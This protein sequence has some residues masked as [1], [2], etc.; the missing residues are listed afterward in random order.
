M[1]PPSLPKYVAA[2]SLVAPRF[3][4]LSVIQ[5]QDSSDPHTFLGIQFE[6]QV[7]T[8]ADLTSALHCA[9]DDESP[10]GVPKV[11]DAGVPL[12]TA[13]PFAVYGSYR[14]NPVGR[15]LQEAFDRALAHLENGKSRAIERAVQLGEAGNEPSLASEAVDITP[16]GGAVSLV[17]AIAEAE[18]YLRENYAG[19]GVIHLT[20]R[21][22]TLAAANTLIYPDGDVLRTTL[23]TLVVAG[24]GY[25]ESVA[26]ESPD[27]SPGDGTSWIYVTGAL[28][29]WQ[30]D[31]P[32]FPDSPGGA[33]D[34]GTNTLT[35]LAEQV[36][37]IAWECLTAA[38]AVSDGPGAELLGDVNVLNFPA[39]TG[40]TDAQL[41][42]AVVPV[43][44]P[45]TQLTP[46]HTLLTGGADRN[47]PANRRSYTVVL[48][49]KAGAGSPTLDG[50]ELPAV[51]TYT[52]SA[53]GEHVLAAAVVATAAGDVVLVM[54]LP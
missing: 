47:I 34:R 25:D 29:G 24:G 38:I 18:E 49:T 40:L 36:F 45:T 46:V 8:A 7:C 13:S 52:V 48:T 39:Q 37:V 19:T 11:T 17:D 30:S 44:T 43:N 31:A 16:A 14:C 33:I 51:G 12:V 9:D 1:A 41:R 21:Q 20:P 3:G 2:P 23:G 35:V 26:P 10:F 32:P 27:E 5:W 50:V 4:I 42:A 6:P 54:E 15:P 53:P 28:Y 22:A